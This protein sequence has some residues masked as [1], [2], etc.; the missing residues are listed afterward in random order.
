MDRQDV[1]IGDPEQP[2]EVDG[3]LFEDVRPRNGYAIGFDREIGA[4]QRLSA[5]AE[6]LDEAIEVGARFRF[7]F[8]KRGTD[9][10]GQVADVLGDKEVMFHE[11]LDGGEAAAIFIAEPGCKNPLQIETQPL[12]GAAGDEMQMAAYAP[13]KLLA[14]HE[15]R[16][17]ARRE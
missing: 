17:F 9:D 2:N 15:E 8:F 14:P 13:Q 4:W 7:A 3:V 11:A 10:R 1:L 6:T 12:F 5:P 16:I